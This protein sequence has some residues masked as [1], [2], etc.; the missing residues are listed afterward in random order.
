MAEFLL[1]ENELGLGDL[2]EGRVRYRKVG[3]AG[4]PK[5]GSR[6]PEIVRF[7]RENGMV[8]VTRD[9]R[10]TEV[11]RVNGV[12]YVSSDDTDFARKVIRFAEVEGDGP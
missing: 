6:D 12:R 7:A 8:I 4:C 10:M 5:K 9:N 11:C 1:D 2:L 3:D